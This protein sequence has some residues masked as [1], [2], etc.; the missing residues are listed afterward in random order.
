MYETVPVL[1]CFIWFS[2]QWETENKTFPWVQSRIY[3]IFL[4]EPNHSFLRPRKTPFSIIS[5]PTVH[6]NCRHRT[7]L[8]KLRK[9]CE[10]PHRTGLTKLRK[11]CET[12]LGAPPY[13]STRLVKDA[14]KKS[15][16]K[17]RKLLS[18]FFGRFSLFFVATRFLRIP[19]KVGVDLYWKLPM[20]SWQTQKK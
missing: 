7:G 6:R 11:E 1:R 8:T 9:E 20:K 18:T 15:K 17:N 4:V 14:Q 12:P 16:E 2:V 5:F 3:L 10:T 19:L 13:W